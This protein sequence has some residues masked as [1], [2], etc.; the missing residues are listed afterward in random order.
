MYQ[1]TEGVQQA[2]AAVAG[3][4]A[5]HGWEAV[6]D[7][8]TASELL[9]RGAAQADPSQVE[10]LAALT[11]MEGGAHEL[12]NATDPALAALEVTGRLTAERGVPPELA[13][14]ATNVVLEV[15]Q[16]GWGAHLAAGAMPAVGPSGGAPAGVAP[17]GGSRRSSTRYVF[18]VVIGVVVLAGIAVALV[19][20]LGRGDREQAAAT[21]VTSTSSPQRGSLGSE[22]DNPASSGANAHVEDLTVS[23]TATANAPAPPLAG[24]DVVTNEPLSLASVKGK[25][26][27]LVFWAHWC[28]HCQKMMP[29]FQQFADDHS[30]AFNVL[31]V[32]TAIGAQPS[33]P[34]FSSPKRLMTTQDI[35]L[36]TMRD[37]D[38]AAATAYDVTGFPAMYL[39]DANGVLVGSAQGEMSPQQLLD[40]AENPTFAPG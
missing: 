25:P 3:V 7:P 27:L 21:S 5:S 35:T 1:A 20:L 28:P 10:A 24:P 9:S 32:A 6:F 17:Q 18:P 16:P 22:E 38:G 12:A 11:T 31:T 8:A 34:Q 15:V 19:F 14:W 2:A 29:V 37:G 30:D 39:V 13:T 36:P 40:F 26:T 23:G 4:V 33:Q